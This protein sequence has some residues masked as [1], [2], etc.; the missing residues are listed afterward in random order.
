MKMAWLTALR[1]LYPVHDVYLLG[2]VGSEHTF[3]FIEPEPS[4]ERPR[5]YVDINLSD[6]L[7]SALADGDR[8]VGDFIIKNVIAAKACR[9]PSPERDNC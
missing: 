4:E 5:M 6:E 9:F 2:G 3:R 7:L 8:I 1:S